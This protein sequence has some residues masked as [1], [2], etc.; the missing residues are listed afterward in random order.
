MACTNAPAPTSS[1]PGMG[2]VHVTN[3]AGGVLSPQF[4]ENATASNNAHVFSI[5]GDFSASSANFGSGVVNVS[6]APE[7]KS[8]DASGLLRI[9]SVY[10]DH[11]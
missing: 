6:P 2:S 1:P 5:T 11:R 4:A 3:H 8:N 7:H 9:T 10:F